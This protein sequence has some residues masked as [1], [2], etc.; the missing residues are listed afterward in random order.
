M[1]SDPQRD[2]IAVHVLRVVSFRDSAAVLLEGGG[3]TFLIWVGPTEANAIARVLAKESP[4]RPLTHELLAYVMSAF[5]IRVKKVVISSIVEGVF[6]ATLSLEQRIEGRPSEEL[7]LDARA[8]DSI[9]IALRSEQE[10]WVTRRVLD[11]VQDVSGIQWP[12][13]G[14]AATERAEPGEDFEFDDEDFPEQRGEV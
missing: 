14:P 1:T 3:K 9:A 2:L 13:P 11:E 4:E 5:E 7:R 6:C 12:T 8:S 10:L